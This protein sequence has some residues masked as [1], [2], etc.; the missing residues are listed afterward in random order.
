MDPNLIQ[1]FM[2]GL[3]LI[4]TVCQSGGIPNTLVLKKSADAKKGCIVN[5]KSIKRVQQTTRLYNKA[6]LCCGPASRVHIFNVLT[7]D[8]QSSNIQE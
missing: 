4:Q 2:K 7:V 3:I 1:Q 5:F 8:M 6:K